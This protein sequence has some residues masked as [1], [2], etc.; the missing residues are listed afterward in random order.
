MVR[1]PVTKAVEGIRFDELD[2]TVGAVDLSEVE[3]FGPC[4]VAE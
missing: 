1:R 4:V 3:Y 2:G